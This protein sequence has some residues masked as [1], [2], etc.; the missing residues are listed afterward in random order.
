MGTSG[1]PTVSFIIPARNE[2][3]Y[4]PATLESLA[5]LKTTV[6]YEQIV[7][8]GK[9][10]DGTP[11]IARE[12]DTRLIAGTGT[13]QGDDRHLGVEAASGRWLAFI[14]ADTCVR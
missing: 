5:R 3:S 8:D 1:E 2:T 12:Y 14:D 4:L 10:D 6:E 9:S 7:V 13:G 11:E